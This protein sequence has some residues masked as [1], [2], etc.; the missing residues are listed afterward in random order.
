VNIQ[1]CRGYQLGPATDVV[2]AA[3]RDARPDLAIGVIDRGVARLASTPGRLFAAARQVGRQRSRGALVPLPPW[4]ASALDEEVRRSTTDVHLPVCPVCSRPVLQ[5]SH[6]VGDQVVCSMCYHQAERGTSFCL[7]CHAPLQGLSESLGARSLEKLLVGPDGYISSEFQPIQLAL[8]HVLRPANLWQ[9]C[10]GRG[11]RALQLLARQPELSWRTIVAAQRQAHATGE[12]MSRV[13]T[14]L[15][16]AGLISGR[17]TSAAWFRAEAEGA[18]QEAR[19]SAGWR[20]AAEAFLHQLAA[21][22]EGDRSSI[23]RRPLSALRAKRCFEAALRF[24]RSAEERGLTVEALDNRSLRALLPN[25]VGGRWAV[26]RFLRSQGVAAETS[27]RPVKPKSSHGWKLLPRREDFGRVRRIARRD[28]RLPRRIRIAALLLLECAQRPG[29]IVVLTLGQILDGSETMLCLGRHPV[30]VSPVLGELLTAELVERRREG[31]RDADWLFPGGVP[32]RHLTA[33]RLCELLQGIGVR[34]E[35]H[36]KAAI[37]ELLLRG[38]HPVAIADLFG[39]TR[40][41][42]SD[43]AVSTGALQLGYLGRGEEPND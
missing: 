22:I 30:E 18:L 32:G 3:A 31:A 17:E 5:C 25:T 20:T 26:D 24:C 28:D 27:L 38:V 19:L 9:W 42:I 29:R 7:W 13:V 8:L 14:A 34:P 2:T 39:Y 43:A 37:T 33:D 35:P 10:E 41:A 6:R 15:E 21:E 23:R 4:V 11:A 16:M 40:R 12:E 36:R 1:R